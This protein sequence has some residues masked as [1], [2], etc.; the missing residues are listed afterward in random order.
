ME[1]LREVLP[2]F[3]PPFDM[4][5]TRASVNLDLYQI[6]D[7]DEKNG[8]IMVNM[9]CHMYYYSKAASWDPA[10]FGG[11]QMVKVSPKTFWTP[12]IG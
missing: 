11:I 12:D 8:A 10:D 9:W 7:V 6:L 3:T 4:K 2:K 1:H 5:D